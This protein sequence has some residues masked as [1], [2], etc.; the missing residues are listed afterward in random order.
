VVFT[1]HFTISFELWL[2]GALEVLFPL[3]FYQLI[4]GDSVDDFERRLDQVGAKPE[5][6]SCIPSF[7]NYV[8][9]S[10]FF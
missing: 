2:V 10:L 6:F 5:L 1:P 8:H 7:L 9:V 3:D 4:L